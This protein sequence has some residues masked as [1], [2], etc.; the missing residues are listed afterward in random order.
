MYDTMEDKKQIAEMILD[1]MHRTMMHYT[2]W[3]SEA[4]H[5]FGREKAFE[6]LDAAWKRSYAVQMRRFSKIFEFEM[7]DNI[8]KPILDLPKEKLE[9][10]RKATAIN[11][12]ANDG[13]WFQA[14]EFTRGMNDAKRTNDSTWSQ[15]SPFEARTI[16]KMLGLGEF[17]GIEG[18]KKA[19]QYR[20]YNYVNKQQIIDEGPNSFLFKMIECRVQLARKRK[21]LPDYPCKSG[22]IVEYTT[23]A[24]TIDP[25]IKTMV[26]SCPPDPHPDDFFCAWR[27]YIEE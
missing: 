5:Q 16:K 23:F 2:F 1:F 4:E 8:P 11:W 3:Y 19:L 18:L 24:E 21:G 7:K 22:G 17:P 15:F 9:E 20:L 10:L 14:I 13:V 6:I 12:L 27:F 26:V 25:R